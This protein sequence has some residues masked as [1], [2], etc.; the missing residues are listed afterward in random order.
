[1]GK[2]M[3]VEFAAT[4]CRRLRNENRR[5]VFTNGVFDLLHVGHLDYLERAR[6]MGHALIV[7][8]NSDTSCRILKGEKHPIIP[9]EERCRM[10]TALNAV[11][12]VVVFDELV[13]VNLIKK[14]RPDVYVKGSD[15][16]QKAWPERETALSLGCQ[17]KLLPLLPGYST[18]NLIQT[19]LARFGRNDIAS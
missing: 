5:V 10:L 19:I 6:R 1:M 13:A 18:T 3:D 17:I 4:Y 16:A 9:Q 14:L 15:Y 7:G 2:E 12:V 11:D 8:L